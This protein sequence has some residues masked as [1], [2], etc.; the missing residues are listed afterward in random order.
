M[1]Y[2]YN[3]HPNTSE[4]I[5]RTEM[6]YDP[7]GHEPMIP[8]YATITQPPEFGEEEIPVFEDNEWVVKSDF[9]GTKYWIDHFTE[10]EIKEI[11][12]SIPD[13]AYLEQP[14]FKRTDKEESEWVREDR[15]S[16]I[17]NAEWRRIRHQDEVTLGM[18]PTEPL[19]PILEYIQALREVPQ[20]EGFPVNVVWPVPPW[21]EEVIND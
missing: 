2:I 18:E 14:E 3:I 16:L 10:K 11:G 13:D 21:E 8:A 9:R 19:L 12:E 15:D 5:G 4:F 17:S 1:D 6:E 7:I 20:Q